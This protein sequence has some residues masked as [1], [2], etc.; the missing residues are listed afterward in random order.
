[1][2]K[3]EFL[4]ELRTS[5]CATAD[6]EL[7][8]VGRSTEGCPYI[9]YWISYYR[10]RSSDHIE[11]AI[12][13][14]APETA[15]AT[16]AR[17][18]IPLIAERVRLGVATWSRTGRITGVP[19]ELAGQTPEMGGSS[20]K[21][22][23]AASSEGNSSVLF[24]ARSGSIRDANPDPIQT[25]LNPGTPLDSDVKGRIESAFSHDFS[26]VRL[27]MDAQAANLS[28]SYNAR[29]FTIGNDIAFRSG[30]YQPGTLLGDALLA[31][32]LAH[33]MQQ[34]NANNVIAPV[35]VGSSGYNQFEED[36]D[37]SAV[38]ATISLWG[39]TKHILNSIAQNFKPRLKSGLQLQ[40]C[41][42]TVKQCPVRI[43][44]GCCR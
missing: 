37:Q 3:G 41:R 43:K 32:E 44:M 34:G 6:A 1:M 7:A 18:Y 22:A 36:A 5:V 33:V 25:Q 38:A 8:A 19:E 9:E 17:D 27:H 40:A 30:E 16:A 4:D 31:H 15:S 26:H 20:T 42:R 24:K 14:Y 23:R 12:H 11:R 39:R 13:M 21:A 29:A 28:S 35:H 2:K 10:T